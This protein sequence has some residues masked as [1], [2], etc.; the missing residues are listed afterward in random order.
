MVQEAALLRLRDR[1]WDYINQYVKVAG[2]EKREE[3]FEL[4]DKMQLFFPHWVIMTCP[5]MHPQIHYLSKNY[6]SVMGLDKDYLMNV[7]PQQYFAHVH[8]ADQED[9]HRCYS[10]VHDFL[11]GIAPEAH[12]EYRCIFHYR[13]RRQ[14]GQY[15]YLHDEKATLNLRESGNLY[16]ALFC[17]VTA[18]KNFSGVKVEIFKQEERLQKISGYKPSADRNT[19]SKREGELVSLIKQGLSTKEIAWYLNISHNTVRNIKSKLFEKYRVSNTVELLNM[20]A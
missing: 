14:N 11:E 8:D 1:L 12:C 5:V 16:Y 3:V 7:S 6:A 4:F 17:D 18:E 15:M 19:L 9:L 10:Y 20:T 2:H 13:F